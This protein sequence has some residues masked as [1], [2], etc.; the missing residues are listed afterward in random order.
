MKAATTPRVECVQKLTK[1][2]DVENE[3]II[4]KHHTSSGNYERFV[5]S[6]K[7]VGW[8]WS[9]FWRNGPVAC[10]PQPRTPI[11]GCPYRFICSET[12]ER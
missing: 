11:G 8:F 10:F 1:I 7:I 6:T 9:K 2:D 12:S 3:S 5:S 4:K